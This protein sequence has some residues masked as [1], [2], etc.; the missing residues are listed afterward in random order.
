MIEPGRDGDLAEEPLLSQTGAKLGPEHLQSH[1]PLQ[2][3]IA[4]HIDSRHPA[5]ADLAL[6]GKA[7]PQA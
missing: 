5:F 3:E 7:I 2:L 6:D 1:L 4:G